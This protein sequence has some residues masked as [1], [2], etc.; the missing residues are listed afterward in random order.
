MTAGRHGMNLMWPGPIDQDSYDL[1]VE[2][3]NAHK[4]DTHRVDGPSSV[5]RV[6]CTMVLAI[7]PTEDEALDIVRRG[8]DGLVRR[9]HNV[10]RHDHLVLPD[11]E[12][13]AALGPA[14]LIMAH[15]E[16][17]IHVGAGTATQIKDRFAGILASGPHRL[18]RAADPDRRHDPRRGEAHDGHLLQRREAG[19]RSIG[20]SGTSAAN[21]RP[22]RGR[23][24]GARTFGAMKRARRRP[25]LS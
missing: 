15:M 17:A 7:A 14:A 5:P 20:L 16:D 8:M 4:G 1:Y 19:P 21:T 24:V 22:F 6:G 9:A 18:H 12:C 2:T 11:D 23:P 13:D 3:W 10:H 25:S